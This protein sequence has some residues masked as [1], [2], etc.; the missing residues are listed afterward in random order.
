MG[1]LHDSLEMDRQG[2]WLR[3]RR[4]DGALNRVPVGFYSEMW[5][6]LHRVRKGATEGNKLI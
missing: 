4:L 3:R 5:N 6:L 1:Q 2:Q